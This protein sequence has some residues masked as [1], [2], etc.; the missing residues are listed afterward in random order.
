M[1]D[2]MKKMAGWLLAFSVVGFIAGY[3]FSDS[4]GLGLCYSDLQTNTFDTSCHQLF[5][6]IGDPMLYGFGALAFVF[7]GLL[8]VPEAFSRWWKFAVWFVPLA[9][10]L[11][12]FTPEPQGWV[13]PIPS[14]E[15][16]FQWVSSFYVIA[17]YS[18]IGLSLRKKN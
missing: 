4:Y 3:V 15:S 8:F 1:I 10:L 2:S 12:I 9:V 16:V 18:L 11:F 17:S 13:S 7:M 14:P 6:R 5:E